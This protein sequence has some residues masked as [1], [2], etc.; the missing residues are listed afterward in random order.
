M[1]KLRPR[2]GIY[3]SDESNIHGLDLRFVYAIKI[4]LTPRSGA[5][6]NGGGGGRRRRRKLRRISDASLQSKSDFRVPCFA[7]RV[8]LKALE[9]PIKLAVFCIQKTLF[10]LLFIAFGCALSRVPSAGATP[11]RAITSLAQQS[12]LAIHL[13]LLLLSLVAQTTSCIS[14]RC[15]RRRGWHEHVCRVCERRRCR[16]VSQRAS[17]LARLSALQVRFP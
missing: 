14:R 5:L 16:L 8:Y 6:R 17:Q 7:V 15:H 10:S 13:G 12:R 2:P 3:V 11:A 1:Q 9:A 4:N